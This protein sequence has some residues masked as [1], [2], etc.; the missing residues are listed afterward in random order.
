MKQE[1]MNQ[2]LN[3]WRKEEKQPFSGWDFSY[4]TDR[5]YEENTPWNYIQLIKKYLKN[6][7][8][9]LDLGTGGGEKLHELKDLF[10]SKTVAT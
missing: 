3:S 6:A 5:I 2:L 1:R 9:L 10:P 8:S 7:N 4:I